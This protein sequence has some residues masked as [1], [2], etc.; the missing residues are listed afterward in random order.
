MLFKDIPALLVPEKPAD[1]CGHEARALFPQSRVFV[2]VAEVFLHGMHLRVKLVATHP[3]F[4]ALSHACAAGP[5][6][7]EICEKPAKLLISQGFFSPGKGA[8]QPASGKASKKL[9]LH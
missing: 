3:L 1:G 9:P 7:I 6:E 2:R 4:D 8:A 5:G